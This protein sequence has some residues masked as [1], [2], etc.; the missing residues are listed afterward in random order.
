MSL[1]SV[2]SLCLCLC[3]FVCPCLLFPSSLPILVCHSTVTCMCVYLEQSLQPGWFPVSQIEETVSRMMG[4]QS[5]HR[6]L[7]HCTGLMGNKKR[8]PQ[9]FLFFPSVCSRN[10]EI[11]KNVDVLLHQIPM[12]WT[13]T[14]AA[15]SCFECHMWNS[16]EQENKSVCCIRVISEFIS[17][18]LFQSCWCQRLHLWNKKCCGPDQTWGSV[19][20]LQR[21]EVLTFVSVVQDFT[22]N[23]SKTVF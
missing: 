21:Y 13:N 4:M 2:S 1:S 23:K 10:T 17:E 7:V 19:P 20:R 22:Q 6:A 11:S 12:N 3:V 15:N 14:T 5:R 18:S 9:P 8:K 16:Q